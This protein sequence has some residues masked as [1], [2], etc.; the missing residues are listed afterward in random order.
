MLVS[1]KCEGDSCTIYTSSSAMM[2]GQFLCEDCWC[3]Y[4]DK[5][6]ALLDYGV[7]IE[8]KDNSWTVCYR[9]R[10]VENA[11]VLQWQRLIRSV[12]AQMPITI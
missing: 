6:K 7:R 12:Y 3:Y 4:R 9:G 1:N 2:Y 11:E 8:L 10:V 5:I